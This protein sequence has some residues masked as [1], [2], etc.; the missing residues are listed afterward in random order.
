MKQVMD[1]SDRLMRTT[2]MDLPDG[3]GYFE[4]YCDGDGIAEMRPA[5]MRGFA[6]AFP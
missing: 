3:E 6:S 2:L 4:D 1:Y 5:A